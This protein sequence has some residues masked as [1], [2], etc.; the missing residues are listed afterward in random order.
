M[1]IDYLDKIGNSI[2]WSLHN[3]FLKMAPRENRSLQRFQMK[4][5]SASGELLTVQGNLELM[6]CS[7]M[8]H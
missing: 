7:R 6:S 5:S 3:L 1:K 4:F 8:V 2:L